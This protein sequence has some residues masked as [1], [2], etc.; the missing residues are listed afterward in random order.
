[1]PSVDEARSIIEGKKRPA[2]VLFANLR[3]PMISIARMHS[4]LVD[5][6]FFD[7]A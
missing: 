5:A 3:L 1:M 7:G 2:D 6:V 4:R